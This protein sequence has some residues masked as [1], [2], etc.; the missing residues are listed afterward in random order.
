MQFTQLALIAASMAVGTMA[1]NPPNDCN[2][3]R[4]NF[5]NFLN[6]GYICSRDQREVRYCNYNSNPVEVVSEYCGPSG[7]CW[8]S[9]DG[10]KNDQTE[11]ACYND[12]QRYQGRRGDQRNAAR[13]PTSCDQVNGF[14]YICS[15]DY[16]T[17]RFCQG[18]DRFSRFSNT[19]D[20]NYCGE[21]TCFA[22]SSGSQG[23]C[24][25]PQFNNFGFGG[26]G[27]RFN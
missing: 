22:S 12:N 27:G 1:Q 9:Q 21:A 7:I 3:L 18:G 16:R 15:E 10:V 23:E 24:I 14:G 26:R 17:L 25:Q 11:L 4:D 5:G 6:Q 8:Y 19:L 2:Q 20:W 13:G